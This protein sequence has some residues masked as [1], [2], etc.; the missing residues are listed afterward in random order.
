MARAKRRTVALLLACFAVWP[1]AH[2]ALVQHY[3]LNPWKFFGWA[4]YTTPRIK[5]RVEV[6]ALD[7]GD[8]V[9]LPLI[10]KEL[11]AAA[12]ERD[13]LRLESGVWGR[14]ARPE[15]LAELVA[16]VLEP[17][18][19]VEIVTLRYWLDP[20]SAR[21]TASRESFFYMSGDTPAPN[22]GR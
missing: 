2:Y 11:A 7:G 19:G 18:E 10:E 5:P 12:A 22:S 20:G 4:M 6:Y 16:E 1:L 14:L 21:L 8:R 17:S 15:R 9:E 13:R 3:G